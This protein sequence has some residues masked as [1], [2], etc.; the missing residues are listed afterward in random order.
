MLWAAS[1]D[2]TV[3]WI[4]QRLCSTGSTGCSTGGTCKSPPPKGGNP[5]SMPPAADP[6]ESCVRAA[7]APQSVAVVQRE[8]LDGTCCELARGHPKHARPHWGSRLEN[9]GRSSPQCSLQQPPALCSPQPLAT[10]TLGGTLSTAHLTKYHQVPTFNHRTA[11]I[12]HDPCSP[13]PAA[14]PFGHCGIGAAFFG[15]APSPKTECDEL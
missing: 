15:P 14:P 10:T 8:T 9:R 1:K 11:S 12:K 7:E 5:L 6:P 2:C 3:H 13:V 4:V